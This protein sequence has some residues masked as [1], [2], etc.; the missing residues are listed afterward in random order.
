MDEGN[1]KHVVGFVWTIIAIANYKCRSLEGN[2]SLPRYLI[3]YMYILARITI[4]ANAR[5]EYINRYVETVLLGLGKDGV[6][7]MVVET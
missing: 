4:A 6:G 3:K 2:L 1:K 7:S 5:W